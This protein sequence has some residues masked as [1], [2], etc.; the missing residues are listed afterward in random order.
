MQ[1]TVIGLALIPLSLLWAYRPVRL[2]QLALITAVFKAAAALIPGGGFGLQPAMV[3]GLLFITYMVGQYAWD[4][5]PR[6]GNRAPHSAAAAGVDV[7]HGAVGKVFA[8]CLCWPDPR[9]AAETGS[10]GAWHGGTPQRTF[11][12]VGAAP[13]CGTDIALGRK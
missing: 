12:T 8:G 1:I 9:L 3:P 4:A 10:P 7:I 5:L 6:R 2:L 11:T 13:C